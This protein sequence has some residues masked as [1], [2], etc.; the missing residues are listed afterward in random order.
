MYSTGPKAHPRLRAQPSPSQPS[1]VFLHESRYAIKCSAGHEAA[2]TVAAIH[3]EGGRRVARSPWVG[4]PG[5]G[6]SPMP[7]QRLWR[8]LDPWNEPPTRYSS[9]CSAFAQI[10]ETFLQT[11]LRALLE[12]AFPSII[13]PISP[14]SKLQLV[15]MSSLILWMSAWTKSTLREHILEWVEWINFLRTT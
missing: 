8:L 14:S 5:R 6:D 4:Y 15:T 13:S 12:R 10:A 7:H 2:G 9:L 11:S 3:K 1:F